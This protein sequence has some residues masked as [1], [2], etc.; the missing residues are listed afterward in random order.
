MNNPD[1]D[2][3]WSGSC[4]ITNPSVLKMCEGDPPKNGLPDTRKCT[5]DFTLGQENFI[6]HPGFKIDSMVTTRYGDIYALAANSVARLGYKHKMPHSVEWMKYNHKNLEKIHQ[7][8]EKCHPILETVD[9]IICV[10]LEFAYFLRASEEEVKVISVKKLEKRLTSPVSYIGTPR[11]GQVV[12]EKSGDISAEDIVKIT[13]AI[14]HEGLDESKGPDFF[15]VMVGD[16]YKAQDYKDI[17]ENYRKF[18]G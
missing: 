17:D 15:E 6:K 8:I 11:D 10:S 13:F 4:T 14:F 7:N 3:D 1:P 16:I 12:R 2:F 9:G 18:D 5:C